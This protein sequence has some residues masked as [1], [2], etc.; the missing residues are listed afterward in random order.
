MSD[1]CVAGP[2]RRTLRR[3]GRADAIHD[4]TSLLMEQFDLDAGQAIARLVRVAKQ[5]NDSIEAV[6]RT[7]VAAGLRRQRHAGTPEPV[8]DQPHHRWMRAERIGYPVGTAVA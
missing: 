1:H 3:Y 4:A 7:C 8:G 6:A 5:Q 2:S